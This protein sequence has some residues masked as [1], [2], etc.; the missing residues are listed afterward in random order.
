[1]PFVIGTSD[2][3]KWPSTFFCDSIGLLETAFFRETKMI[4]YYLSC[5]DP[6]YPYCR[7]AKSV[8]YSLCSR[9]CDYIEVRPETSSS[10]GGTLFG[11]QCSEKNSTFRIAFLVFSSLKFVCRWLSLYVFETQKNI[12]HTGTHYISDILHD[13]SMV[14][15]FFQ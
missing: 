9:F 12:K 15:S 10:L 5:L 11:V 3:F 2:S 14:V 8:F 13:F 7:V 1:M 6:L 4:S